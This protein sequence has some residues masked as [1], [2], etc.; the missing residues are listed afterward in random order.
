VLA[1][2]DGHAFGWCAAADFRELGKDQPRDRGFP[3]RPAAGFKADTFLVGAVGGAFLTVRNERMK[4]EPN[5]A[6]VRTPGFAVANLGDELA[7][8]DLA[9]GSYIGF[10]VTAA[11]VWRLLEEPHTFDSLCQAMM[12]EFDIDADRCR[13][14]VSVLLNKLSA[15]GLIR[16]GDA[17]VA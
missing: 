9:N 14:E 17:S 6:Y 13:H 10:N 3:F 12:T 7:V 15:S 1:V 8:L 5:V 11:H 4:I 2:A 16:T